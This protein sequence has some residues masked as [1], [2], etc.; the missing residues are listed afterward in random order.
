MNIPFIPIT[1]IGCKYDEF[2]AKCEPKL[3]KLFCSALRFLCHKHGADLLFA[4]LKHINTFKNAMA[5]HTFRYII[6]ESADQQKETQ[7]EQDD[8]MP[9]QQQ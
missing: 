9:Q 6:S 7:L 5:Y 1:V 8:E 2:A 4:S 3:K